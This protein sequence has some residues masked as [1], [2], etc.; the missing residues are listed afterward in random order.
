MK[1][2]DANNPEYIE[3]KKSIT[4]V[5]EHL[6]KQKEKGVEID[7]IYL[8]LELEKNHKFLFNPITDNN[9]IFHEEIWTKIDETKKK[10]LNNVFFVIYLNIAACYLKM[11]NFYEVL[12]ALED[13]IKINDKNIVLYFQRSQALAYNKDSHLE[14]LY[15]AKIDLFQAREIMLY[16][17]KVKKNESSIFN[18]KIFVEY[19]KYLEERISERKKYEKILI[20]GIIFL[21]KASF[22]CCI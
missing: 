9:V 22:P 5:I 15:Q 6:K 17:N 13:A 10:K 16:E 1:E 3:F 4:R 20:T 14:D 19:Y 8:N 12:A 18:E 21:K 7:S 2:P 11:C